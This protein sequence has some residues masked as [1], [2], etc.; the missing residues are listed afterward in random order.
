MFRMREKEKRKNEM[1]REN[2]NKV[3][4]TGDRDPVHD[5]VPVTVESIQQKLN[6]RVKGN[7]CWNGKVGWMYI[8][9]SFP[10]VFRLNSVR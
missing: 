3:E 5:T 7:N 8:L 1:E 6:G 4:Q 10:P 9:F 2:E